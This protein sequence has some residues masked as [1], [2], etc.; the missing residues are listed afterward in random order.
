MA[1]TSNFRAVDPSETGPVYNPDPETRK[2][3]HFRCAKFHK[4]LSA[5]AVCE[6]GIV[7]KLQ[8][9][10]AKCWLRVGLLP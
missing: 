10:L 3:L 1:C 6:L 2:Y 9:A 4:P 5:T 7:I 8:R